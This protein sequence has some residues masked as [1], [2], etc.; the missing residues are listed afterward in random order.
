MGQVSSRGSRALH[1]KRKAEN[2]EFV[3]R[4]REDPLRPTT[5]GNGPNWSRPY[6]AVGTESYIIVYNRA[7]E[8]SLL[9]FSL[10]CIQIRV[11][12]Y[13][14]EGGRVEGAS[15]IYMQVTSRDAVN[16]HLL[17]FR[18]LAPRPAQRAGKR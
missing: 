11:L 4:G 13:D 2:I 16:Y 7:A 8:Q 6:P 1:L 15:L 12:Y 10:Q 18:F 14:K 5:L 3:I 9:C 17:P